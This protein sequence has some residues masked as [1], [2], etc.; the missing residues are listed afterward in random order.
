VLSALEPLAGMLE[1]FIP[2]GGGGGG[3][4]IQEGSRAGAILTDLPGG[5]A[6]FISFL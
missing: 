3:A 6:I 1:P 4:S 5:K 2:R